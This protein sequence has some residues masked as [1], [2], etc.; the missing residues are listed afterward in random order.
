MSKFVLDCSIA[1]AWCFE[2]ETSEVTD[3]LLERVRD[4]GAGCPFPLVSGNYQ[5]LTTG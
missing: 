3:S 5:R 4:H 2:D 1:A